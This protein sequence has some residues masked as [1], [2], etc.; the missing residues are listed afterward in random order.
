MAPLTAG[1]VSTVQWREIENSFATEVVNVFEISGTGGPVRI[2]V[3][4]LNRYL[5]LV[6]LIVDT[7]NE[8]LVFPSLTSEN[9]V[10]DGMAALTPG[11]RGFVVSDMENVSVKSPDPIQFRA[12]ADSTYSVI[13]SKFVGGV[14]RSDLRISSFEITLESERT[15]LLSDDTDVQRVE[16]EPTPVDDLPALARD[17]VL[18]DG[19]TGEYD[20]FLEYSRSGAVEGRVRNH[21]FG[22][23]LVLAEAHRQLHGSTGEFDQLWSQL[24]AADIQ[25]ETI[26]ALTGAAN[27]LLDFC[28]WIVRLKY[29]PPEPV[30][31]A[32]RRTIRGNVA[33]LAS[34]RVPIEEIEHTPDGAARAPSHIQIDA[35]AD[36]LS[37]PPRLDDLELTIRTPAVEFPLRYAAPRWRFDVSGISD[38]ARTELADSVDAVEAYFDYVWSG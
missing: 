33:R 19:S 34:F 21:Y 31:D 7:T 8:A 11:A 36:D 4:H 20:G 13:L 30:L 27:G 5:E 24:I 16:S 12:D 23:V 38:F 6:T 29:D 17:L 2:T 26:E 3:D 15:G 32:V 9:P 18:T 1:C 14:D 10:Q 37:L 28:L 22:A 35:S 25:A